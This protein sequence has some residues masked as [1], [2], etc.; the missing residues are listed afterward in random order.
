MIQEGILE[1]RHF[2]RIMDP[3]R[4]FNNI[5]GKKLI[6]CVCRSGRHRSE[7]VRSMVDTTL[8]F[9]YYDVHPDAGGIET[10]QLQSRNGWSRIC[11]QSQCPECD[12]DAWMHHRVPNNTPIQ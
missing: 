2:D 1:D 7:A 6:V 5:R 8:Q 9:D 11:K 10:I 4:K 12:Y 3:L